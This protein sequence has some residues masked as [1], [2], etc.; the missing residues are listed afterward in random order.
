MKIYKMPLLLA[1]ML[2]FAFCKKEVKTSLPEKKIEVTANKATAEASKREEIVAFA[3]KYLGTKYCYAGGRP[4]R[5]FDCSGFVNYVFKHF[6]IELPRSSSGFTNIGKP[7]KPEEFR[8]GDVLV[9]YGYQDNTSVG[10]VGIIC[11]ANGMKSKFIHSSS[12]KEMAV[13]ISE[14]GSDMYTKRFYKC[15]DPFEL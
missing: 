11:E 4:E 6:D 13:I 9:F 7:L 5:G 8:V 12:G 1:M 15:I 10:H 3:K 2:T 14:L